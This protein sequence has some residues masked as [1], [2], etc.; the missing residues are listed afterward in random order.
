MA[1]RPRVV[2]D[3]S[4]TYRRLVPVDRLAPPVTPSEDVYVI[5]HMGL[6]RVDVGVWQ[7]VVD[8]LVERPFTLDHA[9]LTGLPAVEVTSVLECFDTP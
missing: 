1:D 8:G 5:A 9:S 6:A 7:L 2:M 3:P 4:A